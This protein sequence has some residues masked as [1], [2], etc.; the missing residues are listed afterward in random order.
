M[1]RAQERIEVITWLRLETLQ[2]GGN[3][4]ARHRLAR[5][6]QGRLTFFEIR[7]GVDGDFV[8]LAVGEVG[9]LVEG[10]GRRLIEQ[11]HADL[12]SRG[13]AGSAVGFG[14]EIRGKAKKPT[15]VPC[16]TASA[17]SGLETTW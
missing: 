15:T 4:S 16:N 1:T 10:L 14:V 12:G 3:Q 17:F 5:A 8:E 6:H 13:D 11:G 9:V 7:L 2:Y